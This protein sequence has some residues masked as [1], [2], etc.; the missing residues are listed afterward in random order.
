MGT[1]KNFGKCGIDGILCHTLS[2][3]GIFDIVLTCFDASMT[4]PGRFRGDIATEFSDVILAQ[5]FNT[6]EAMNLTVENETCQ[7]GPFAFAQE[8]DSHGFCSR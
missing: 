1:L 8:D 6:N 7:A 5:R 2:L 3:L 4:P